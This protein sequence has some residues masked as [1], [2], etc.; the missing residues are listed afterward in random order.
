MVVVSGV[1]RQSRGSHRLPESKKGKCGEPKKRE[2]YLYNF[3]V[4]DGD[5]DSND[6][7][8]DE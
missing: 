8:D 1:M 7:N 3:V 4:L 2:T 5:D 6:A